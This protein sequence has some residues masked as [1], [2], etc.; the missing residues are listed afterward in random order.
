MAR[1]L[2]CVALL[3]G[4][5]LLGGCD[6]FAP[7]TSLDLSFSGLG[8]TTA[9]ERQRSLFIIRQAWEF[10][11][12]RTGDT[13]LLAERRFI[14]R[15][16]AFAKKLKHTE[17]APEAARVWGVLIREHQHRFPDAGN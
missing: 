5:A 14:N 10:R 13:E 7:E 6:A 4:A 15:Y 11:P 3:L 1:R 8:R 9:R 17:S 2:F 16:G 12:D